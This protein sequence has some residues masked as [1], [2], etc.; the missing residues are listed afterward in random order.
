VAHATPPFAGPVAEP[1]NL[2]VNPA[3]RGFPRITASY[4][5][6]D[7]SVQLAT[8]GRIAYN[9]YSR[10]RWSASGTSHPT[11]WLEVDF[12]APRRV[13]RVALHFVGNG[14]SLAAPRDFT[15][16]YWTGRDWLP[17]RVRRRLPQQPEASAVNTV[18]ID[19]VETA[20]V[21][22]V[23]EHARPAATAVTELL[24]WRDGT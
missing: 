3:G 22:V 19:P 17:A 9:L 23:M 11:D 13:S 2:A 20:R 5:A 21:R 24:I 18:W 10:N 8:D 15:V 1:G 4:T 6:P 14:R 12:G 16:E 7:D